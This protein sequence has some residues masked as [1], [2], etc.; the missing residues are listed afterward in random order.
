MKRLL[1]AVL[2]IL[3]GAG[4]WFGILKAD[5]VYH[6]IWLDIYLA[7]FI[8]LPIM[9]ALL[10]ITFSTA[11]FKI[12]F[13]CIFAAVANLVAI[14]LLYQKLTQDW[15]NLLFAG[16]V[17]FYFLS[18]FLNRRSYQARAKLSTAAQV[19]G[20]GDA[21]QALKL[22][23]EARVLSIKGAN[24]AEQAQAE[25]QIGL[26]ALR[27]GERQ[28]AA[29]SI[30]TALALFRAVGDKKRSKEAENALAQ[31]R[32]SGVSIPG[33]GSAEEAAKHAGISLDWGLIL[34][35]A[36]SIAGVIALTQLWQVEAWQGSV[37]LLAGLGLAAFLLVYGAYGVA[38]LAVRLSRPAWASSVSFVVYT[39]AFLLLASGVA[40]LVVQGGVEVKDFP[41][42]LQNALIWLKALTTEWPIWAVSAIVFC[43]LLLVLVSLV[44]ASGRFTLAWGTKPSQR[45]LQRASEALEAEKWE[46][47]ITQLAEIDLLDKSNVQ[48]HPQILFYLAFAYSMLK[49]PTEAQKHLRDLLEIDPGHKEGRYLAGYI[50][51]Q[52]GD[53]DS[54]EEHWRKLFR[55]D[56]RF[57]PPGAVSSRRAAD[58]Y[59]CLTLYRKAMVTMKQ[60]ARQGISLLAEAGRIEALDKEMAEALA[61]AHLYQCVQLIRQGAWREA[62]QEVSQAQTKLQPL[63]SQPGDSTAF[64]KLNGLCLVGSALL[65]FQQARY[66]ETLTSLKAADEAT[67]ALAQKRNFFTQ[68]GQSLLEQLLR[69]MLVSQET[70]QGR[71]SPL[72]SRDLHFLG[73]LAQLRDLRERLSQAPDKGWQS[74]LEKIEAELEKSLESSEDFDEG[75]AMLGLFYYYVS[76]DQS[77]QKKGIELLQLVQGR[78][79]SSFVKE[80]LTRHETQEKRRASWQKTYFDLLEQ[81]M[82]FSSVPLAEREA[83]RQRVLETMKATGEL[84]TLLGE[85]KLQVAT[86][87]EREP[88]VEEYSTHAALLLVKLEELMQSDK[89]G[90]IPPEVKRLVESLRDQ[91]EALK[92]TVQTLL[93]TEKELLSKAQQLF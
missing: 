19:L 31:L 8:A 2:I 69:S 86:R 89:G 66:A 79:G 45:A 88:T 28:S 39:I 35:G 49:Q 92:Q 48:I 23:Q 67:A 11:P 68:P 13:I 14:S 37:Q 43:S 21:R 34:E 81:Y 78:V 72:F 55:I 20:K 54:A 42:A 56:P 12:F 84:E 76:A 93:H 16:M 1:S 38:S 22:A 82:R 24:R 57:G 17:I 60:D 6:S 33:E 46:G 18:A 52:T 15:G 51:L 4:A 32:R 50:A 44:T 75:C 27:L 83:M 26:A 65:S 59:L 36:L 47:A 53:L 30:S 80:T 90:Q 10:R 77:K 7:A 74:V 9:W 91:N 71:I 40:L 41:G 70:N 63:K 25:W 5:Q 87:R 85:R 61:R 73:A 29:R 64:S 58:Y 3:A 62:E